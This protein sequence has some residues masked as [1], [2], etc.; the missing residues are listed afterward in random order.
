MN[1]KGKSIADCCR[2]KGISEAI[3]YRW[4]KEYRGLHPDQA[5]LLKELLAEV[6]LDNQIFK[7]TAGSHGVG[8]GP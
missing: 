2:D 7:C 8:R 3:Y 6:M 4:K 5:K 1:G